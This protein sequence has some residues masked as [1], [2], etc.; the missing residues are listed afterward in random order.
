MLFHE[1][2]V[3]TARVERNGR[4]LSCSN[5]QAD[6]LARFRGKTV[7][8]DVPVLWAGERA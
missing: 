7:T 2:S 3:A 6:G 4:S 5:K 8:L 1:G